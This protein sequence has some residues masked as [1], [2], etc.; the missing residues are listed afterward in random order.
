[1][2]RAQESWARRAF[3]KLIYFHEVDEGGH[4]A[5]WEHPTLFAEELRAAFRSLR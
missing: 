1:V 3:P 4:F 5:M 2:F